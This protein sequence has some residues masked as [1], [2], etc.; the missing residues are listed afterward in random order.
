ML[1]MTHRDDNDGRGAKRD[2][3]IDEDTLLVRAAQSG[4]IRAFEKLI[5]RYERL[6]YRT[7][8]YAVG[9]EEDAADLTQEILLKLWHGLPHFQGNARFLTWFAK[10]MRNTCYDFLRKKRRSHPTQSLDMPSGQDADT[11]HPEIQD[12]S[13]DADPHEVLCRRECA[14][15]VRAA[16]Q[17]LSEEHRTVILLRDIEG[18][19]YETIAGMLGLEVGTVK[20]RLSR[21]RAHLK[22]ILRAE[23]FFK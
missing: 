22:S 15:V 14:S 19:S 16:M 23:D 13:S 5:R 17:K 9:N 20:S 6:V 18:A 4:D 1:F 10:I 3:G 2:D 11:P 21:A 7:A 12:A 8:F